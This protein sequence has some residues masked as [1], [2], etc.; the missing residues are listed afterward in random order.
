MDWRRCAG[1][2]FPPPRGTF[3]ERAGELDCLR[4]ERKPDHA[5]KPR[6]WFSFAARGL[7][8]GA[9]C[10]APEVPVFFPSL[11]DEWL[12]VTIF[13]IVY[14]PGDLIGFLPFP[15]LSPSHDCLQLFQAPSSL[16]RYALY[17]KAEGARSFPR[18][19]SSLAFCLCHR[20]RHRAIDRQ[21]N[22]DRRMGDLW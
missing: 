17:A 22:G 6:M 3:L 9:A 14:G 16:Q 19:V 4:G 13:K 1:A 15:P 8:V 7:A 12:L 5:M 2:L 20:H 21:G 11:Q 10:S 18:G